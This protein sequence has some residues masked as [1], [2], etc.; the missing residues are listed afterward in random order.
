MTDTD[1]QDR[2]LLMDGF[3]DD[4]V[5]SHPKPPKTSELTLESRPSRWLVGQP[6]DRFDQPGPLLD[7]D[8]PERL[9]GA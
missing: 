2:E 8:L 3:V 7:I 9:G 6:V 4:S 1:D 5:A